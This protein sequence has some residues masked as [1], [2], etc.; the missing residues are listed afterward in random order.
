MPN[1]FWVKGINHVIEDTH[2]IMK[3][4][5]KIYLL[6]LEYAHECNAGTSALSTFIICD[7][8]K[9]NKSDVGDVVF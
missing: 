8:I 6:H 4:I 3:Q 9:R 2:L 1:L 5:N 7:M